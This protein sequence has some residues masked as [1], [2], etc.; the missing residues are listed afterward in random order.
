MLPHVAVGCALEQPPVWHWH[1]HHLAAA[2]VLATVLLLLSKT[3][4]TSVPCSATP[5]PLS[6]HLGEVER[7]T[8]L[9]SRSVTV[10]VLDPSRVAPDTTTRSPRTP[11]TILTATTDS[12]LRWT[13]RDGGERDVRREGHAM[14]QCLHRQLRLLHRS[15][16]PRHLAPHTTTA[17]CACAHG[18]QRLRVTRLH[19]GLTRSPKCSPCSGNQYRP[20]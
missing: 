14:K 6:Q 4:H 8:G 15:L 2:V 17:A 10:T 5:T 3:R 12:E 11:Q 7:F 16:R 9:V 19:A 18:I 13:S 20:A 1:V